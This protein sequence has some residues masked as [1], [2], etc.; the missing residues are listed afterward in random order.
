MDKN[1]GIGHLSSE[2]L[3]K[4]LDTI[5]LRFDHPICIGNAKG[6]IVASYHRRSTG[7]LHGGFV[8]I[9]NE[10]LSELL[11]YEDHEI[12]GILKGVNYPLVIGHKVVGLIGISG[13]VEEVSYF[14]G[15]IRILIEQLVQ[16]ADNEYQR[17]SA[18]RMYSNFIYEWLLETRLDND[19]DFQARGRMLGI[20][21]DVPRYVAVL[22]IRQDASLLDKPSPP[23]RE[24]FTLPSILNESLTDHIRDFLTARDPQHCCAMVGDTYVLL[25][26]QHSAE[27]IHALLLDLQQ[28]VA[29]SVK[30]QQCFIGVG[31]LASEKEDVRNSYHQARLASNIASQTPKLGSI[32][33][34]GSLDLQLLVFSAP[35]RYK[36]E[37]F[38]RVFKGFSKEEIRDAVELIHT[39]IDTNGSLKR[40]AEA[41]FIHKNSLQ[42][43]LN[44]FA[45]Q[46]GYDLRN[47]SDISF[48]AALASVYDMGMEL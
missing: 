44:R 41:L 24:T 16:A 35:Q 38:D 4:I 48:L 13:D 21:T 20:N 22:D 14:S 47:L 10:N 29:T 2:D 40:C 45:R 32:V 19:E 25:L 5:N 42:Y 28:Q 27:S 3:Q 17:S 26:R 33:Y 15:L 6:Y 34:Y 37:L 46:T 9:L 31:M 11:L 18:K 1:E 8:K 12:P 23:E 7:Q 30:S 36:K 43:R 39:Y